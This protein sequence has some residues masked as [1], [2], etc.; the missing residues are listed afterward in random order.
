MKVH[1]APV[2]SK[3]KTSA[4][5]AERHAGDASAGSGIAAGRGAGLQAQID[6]SPRMVAQ[7][8][9]IDA[10]FGGAVPCRGEGQEEGFV[11]A[12]TMPV[13]QLGAP[14]DAQA[15]PLQ[16]GFDGAV[17]Q[18]VEAV[19]AAGVPGAAS[20][21]SPAAKVNET[22]MPNPLKSGIES[23]SGMD[24]SSVRV[25]RN[26]GKP[27]QLNAQ[28]YA[29]GHD[30]HLGPGQERHL[31]H[32]AW[33]VVQQRQG[34]VKATVQLQ[35]DVPVN[36]DAGLEREADVM[37][38]KALSIGPDSP[39]A[40]S[41]AS[42]SNSSRVV[43]RAVGFEFET[44]LPV[45]SA[46]EEI[47][48]KTL[49]RETAGAKWVTDTNNGA[50]ARL[51]SSRKPDEG[52]SS[53]SSVPAVAPMAEFPYNGSIVE[54]VTKMEINELAPDWNARIDEM[55]GPMASD[56][57]SI[58]QSL[59]TSNP[60]VPHVAKGGQSIGFPTSDA[61]LRD[62]S[63]SDAFVQATMATSAADIPGLMDLST[64]YD[65]PI[66]QEAGPKHQ[67]KQERHQKRF[68][69]AGGIAQGAL[70]RLAVHHTEKGDKPASSSDPLPA[71]GFSMGGDPSAFSFGA[72]GAFGNSAVVSSGTDQPTGF[73]FGGFGKQTG[74]APGEGS[75]S[76]GVLEG[77]GAPGFSFGL[78]GGPSGLSFGGGIHDAQPSATG[79]FSI[80]SSS[81]MGSDLSHLGKEEVLAM[82]DLLGVF[83][84]LATMINGGQQFDSEQTSNKN[85]TSLLPK[86]KLSTMINQSLSPDARN[87]VIH[88]SA[89]LVGAFLE[90]HGL[91]AEND[92]FPADAM[93][94]TVQTGLQ[95]IF[96]GS[97]DPFFDC[98]AYGNDMQELGPDPLTAEGTK[99]SAVSPGQRGP[100]FEM[101]T[102][103]G[104][105]PAASWVSLARRIVG[106]LR[107]LNKKDPD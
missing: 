66:G 33:H 13:A 7:R 19:P 105:H 44:Q 50:L 8:R 75:S 60:T 49:V 90:L 103:S 2:E 4:A 37:G 73:S 99:E 56:V 83:H 107:G 85:L 92:F 26:S 54:V 11:P 29:Q 27:A 69:A 63:R 12:R 61:E 1:D 79:G 42:G 53:A 18:R 81:S 67:A 96:S 59:A 34:R 43:Q 106:D 16:G 14:G 45:W 17:A 46:T 91:T 89:F 41:T 10:L 47:P 39:P 74:N 65:L 68:Q 97:D 22:G 84:A 64:Q 15:S 38:G 28:A 30:I 86:T 104:R 77:G 62:F 25:H 71:T 88:Q 36:D 78:S 80:A 57:S 70:Q 32:E 5:A 55:I 100:V 51:K 48:P 76:T 93:S 23:L 82:K 20:S 24:M 35:G 87:L 9:S 94:P 31:P 98:L 52:D 40:P 3:R 72:F 101:R 95:K 21:A 6:R 58:E 102:I